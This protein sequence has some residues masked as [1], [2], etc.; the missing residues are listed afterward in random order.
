MDTHYIDLDT[1]YQFQRDF[2]KSGFDILDEGLVK[3]RI[4]LLEQLGYPS[5]DRATDPIIAYIKIQAVKTGILSFAK[6][7]LDDIRAVRINILEAVKKSN[8]EVDTVLHRGELV[9]TR[10]ST[11]VFF[12]SEL[13]ER[14]DYNKAIQ[15]P[16]HY[17][18]SVWYE[19]N[20]LVLGFDEIDL[21]I[22]LHMQF[23]RAGMASVVSQT[24]SYASARDVE[25]L[26]NFNDDARWILQDYFTAVIRVKN[27]G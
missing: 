12:N 19:D 25:R 15:L 16:I 4:S 7:V 10:K 2:R 5:I 23:P 21:D 18:Q 26:Q 1:A 6:L 27:S 14:K 11:I 22:R 8:N 13:D 9:I 20:V 17:L 3:S 24:S